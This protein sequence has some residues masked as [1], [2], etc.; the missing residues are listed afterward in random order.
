MS[1]LGRFLQQG[2]GSTYRRTDH[3]LETTKRN[4]RKNEFRLFLSRCFVRVDCG[5][6]NFIVIGAYRLPEQPY[7]LFYCFPSINPQGRLLRNTKKTD[8]RIHFYSLSQI[9][10][11]IIHSILSQTCSTCRKQGRQLEV[12]RSIQFP[13]QGPIPP[14]LIG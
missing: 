4:S 5:N 3:I 6:R 2:L 8:D 1:L 7:Y 11:T 13:P 10:R 9:G 12:N 14:Q